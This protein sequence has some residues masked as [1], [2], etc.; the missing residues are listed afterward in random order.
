ML[1]RN[2][3][4]VLLLIALWLGTWAVKTGRINLPS[5]EPAVVD[6]V[7]YVY[8]KDQG[9]VPPAVAVAL[10]ELNAAGSIVATEFEDDTV[11]GDGEVPEQYKIASGAA[12]TIPCVV[13]QDG[14]VVVRVVPIDPAV[15]FAE[16]KT[17]VLEAAK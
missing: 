10:M 5:V 16:L 1:N 6:R 13:A 3:L 15:P 12:T 9:G 14:A 4:V 8:E 7:T 17:I 11:D 2:N